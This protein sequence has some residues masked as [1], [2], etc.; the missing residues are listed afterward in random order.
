M[1]EDTAAELR[2]LCDRIAEETILQNDTVE[3][4]QMQRYRIIH[5][6][7]EHGQWVDIP[8]K[9]LPRLD[10]PLICHFINQGKALIE[11]RGERVRKIVI[12][13]GA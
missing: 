9:L 1:N 3:G 13:V 7:D 4:F 8:M 5:T 11:G 10:K 6:K 2:E 12:G